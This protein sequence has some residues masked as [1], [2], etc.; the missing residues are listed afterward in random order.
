MVI[1]EIPLKIFRNKKIYREISCEK[2]TKKKSSFFPGKSLYNFFQN[3]TLENI[4][5]KSHRRSVIL[6]ILGSIPQLLQNLTPIRELFCTFLHLCYSYPRP[7][8]S[9]L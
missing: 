3:H 9:S 4:F 7:P 8:P 2:F 5:Q 6:K 1:K